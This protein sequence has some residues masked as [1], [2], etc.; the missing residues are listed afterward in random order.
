MRR[1]LACLLI[2]VYADLSFAD[3][4]TSN[5]ASFQRAMSGIVNSAMASRGYVASDPRT[6][7]T[8]AGMNNVVAGVAGTAAAVTIG[9]ITAPAWGT[10]LVAAGVGSVISYGVNL[11]LNALTNWLFNPD[12]TVTATTNGIVVDAS[13]GIKSGGGYWG[14]TGA[15]GGDPF[16]VGQQSFVVTP[17]WAT[18]KF[19]VH[20]TIASTATRKVYL[21]NRIHPTYCAAGGCQETAIY[22]DYV[23]SGAP[24]DCAAGSFINSGNQCV[25]YGYA[26][27]AYTPVT[28]PQTVAQAI[29]AVPDS[30][31]NKQ[32]NPQLL[33]AAAN[34]LWQQAALQPGYAGL[35]YPQSKPITA[36]EASTWILNNPIINPTVNSFISPQ[37]GPNAF[38]LPTS[39]SDPNS[40]PATSPT[41]PNA[42]QPAVNLGPD[43]GVPAPTLEQTPTAHEILAPLL[44]LMPDLRG[45]QLPG[46]S[47][48][49]PA[50]TF[51][52][53]GHQFTLDQ[54]CTL[55][56]NNQATVQA[57][58]LAAWAILAL[59]IVLAA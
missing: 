38:Q 56:Q 19:I 1:V 36:Q 26:A 3:T 57:A 51:S 2:F 17:P 31:K 18:Y 35:P 11:G 4:T 47:S 29:A 6:Y 39:A 59:L 49:C 53:W 15:K 34:L 52:V 24:I 46:H 5:D 45:F 13:S 41:N 12:K 43:P 27:P 9:G 14:A 37:T 48:Q 22:V 16:A 40:T 55:M 25:A 7:S 33:A 10:I 32:I 50:P 42:V 28:T 20:P 54:Q 44:N 58:F 8:L 21:A 23:A 30:D